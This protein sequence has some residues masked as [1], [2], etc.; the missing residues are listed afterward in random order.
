MDVFPSG[1]LWRV[2]RHAET[3]PAVLAHP[4]TAII[5]AVTVILLQLSFLLLRDH[6]ILFKGAD[7]AEFIGSVSV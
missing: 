1:T 7:S 6:S 5:A 2:T 4:K 3:T